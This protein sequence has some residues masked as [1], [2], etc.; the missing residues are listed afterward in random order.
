MLL[1]SPSHG[2]I[3]HV[4]LLKKRCKFITFY[5]NTQIIT[6]KTDK[7]ILNFLQIN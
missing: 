4:M 1:N 5:F 2:T 7:N 6:K 3:L